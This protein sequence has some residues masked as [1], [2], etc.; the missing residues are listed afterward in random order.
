MSVLL[1]SNNNKLI[2]LAHKGGLNYGDSMIPLT[3]SSIIK[4]IP[5][6]AVIRFLKRKI[7]RRRKAKKCCMKRTKRTRKARKARKARK[8]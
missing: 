3:S 8:R 5:G 6:G 4:S 7:R 2:D 1:G